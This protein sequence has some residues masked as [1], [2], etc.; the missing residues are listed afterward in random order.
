MVLHQNMLLGACGWHVSPT[1]LVSFFAH[2]LVH[3][4]HIYINAV[5]W[6]GLYVLHCNVAAAAAGT[7]FPLFSFSFLYR[8]G[9]PEKMN[10]GKNKVLNPNMKDTH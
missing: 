1:Y 3:L 2:L 4:Q 8:L 6:V 7:V 9:C 5:A 10:V